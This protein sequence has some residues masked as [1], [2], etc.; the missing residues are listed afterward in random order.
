MA[1]PGHILKS[2]LIVVIR[3]IR[4]RLLYLIM[5]VSEA[6]Q[7]T[8]QGYHTINCVVMG[9]RPGYTCSCSQEDGSD[10]VESPPLEAL[11]ERGAARLHTRRRSSRSRTR[12]DVDG[13]RFRGSKSCSRSSTSGTAAPRRSSRSLSRRTASPP[14]SDESLANR[15]DTY[16]SFADFR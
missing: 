16:W 4:A 13:W 15:L 3:L 14:G 6:G 10:R 2:L 9:P 11:V 5:N 7:W 12:R 8:Q 1:K